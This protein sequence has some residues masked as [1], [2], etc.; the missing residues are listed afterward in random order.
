MCRPRSEQ[1]QMLMKQKQ[2]EEATKAKEDYDLALEK[3]EEYQQHSSVLKGMS[4]GAGLDD[5]IGDLKTGL[6]SQVQM[7]RK[8]LGKATFPIVAGQFQS[9]THF[10]DCGWHNKGLR[11]SVYQ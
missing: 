10:T 4:E 9:V 6:S 1:M 11:A 7:P 2:L 5:A 8:T 3:M